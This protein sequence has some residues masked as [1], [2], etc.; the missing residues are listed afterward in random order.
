M[1]KEE[2]N[3]AFEFSEKL[4]QAASKEED[5]TVATLSKTVKE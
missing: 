4:Y 1:N 3:E 5:E 2:D